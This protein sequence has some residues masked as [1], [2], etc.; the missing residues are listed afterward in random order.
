M[1]RKTYRSRQESRTISKAEIPQ[2]I[3]SE[4]RNLCKLQ[5]TRRHT[6][7]DLPRLRHPLRQL[8]LY[9]NPAHCFTSNGLTQSNRYF[10]HNSACGAVA[11]ES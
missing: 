9:S 1:F 7:T 3:D 6:A 8:C 4:C 5:Q 2:G 11:F 10:V